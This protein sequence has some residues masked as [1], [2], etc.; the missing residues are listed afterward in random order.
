MGKAQ[1]D[2]EIDGFVK[3]LAKDGV[4]VGAHAV[5]P[6]ASAIIQQFAIMIENKMDIEKA[7]KTVFAHPTYSEASYESL[8]G[9]DVGAISLPPQ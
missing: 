1:A 6:E 4:I 9:L 7:T 2:D 5:T 3:V 8:L